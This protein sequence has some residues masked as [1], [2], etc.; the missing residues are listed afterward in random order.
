[1]KHERATLPTPTSTNSFW[2]S[3]PN[4]FLLGHRT[5]QEL[6]AEAD[7]VIVGSGITGTSAARFLAEDERAQGKSIVVLEAR[8]ACWGA[9]GRNGGHCQPLL[10]DR[11]SEVA[12]F[13]LKNV[14]AVRSYV[15]QNNVPCEWRDVAGCRTF[16]TEEAMKEAE[17]EID[18]LKNIAPEIAQYVTITKDKEELKK[19]RVAPDCIGAT[20]SAGAAS[21][22]PYK[23][24]T[25]ILKKL[26]TDGH[27]N[28][29]TT[30]P[31]TE[32][33]GASDG[34]HT[35]HTPRGSITS[36]TVILATNGYTSALLPHFADLIVPVRG[37]MSALFPPNNATLLPNSYGMVAALG[38]PANNDDYLIQRPFSG[39]PNP[40]G[41]LMFGGGRGAGNLP[42]IGISDDSV[43][44]E[45]AAAYLR[46]ALLKVLELDGETEG[47]RELKAAQQWT[48]IMGYSRDDHPWVG[49][50]PGK[51]GLWLCGG[52]TGHGMPNGTLCGKAVV[53]MVLGE[54]SGE[55]LGVLSERMV[56]K[57]DIPKSYLLTKERIDRARSL[58]TVLQQDE[59]GVHMNGVV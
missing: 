25:F 43:I 56:E 12:E 20:L 47:V 38:Q 9:T 21:L 2:H 11:S 35:L 14:A 29:Q 6:P 42:N 45:G 36:K 44:D 52:Y 49:K 50:V 46:G 54:D 8:E 40:A 4:E 39:V 31:V 1:M 51:E 33:N 10:F 57:G 22:W 59:Q 34:K 3:E 48:G 30:T 7:I 27:I 18:H 23:L 55:D 19:H 24:I 37:E 58:L 17:K 5:T 28:L 53:D 13:E 15:Q 26:V 41:H 16:W 32:I